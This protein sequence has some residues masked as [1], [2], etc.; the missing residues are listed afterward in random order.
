[1]TWVL[2]QSA[3]FRYTYSTI[4]L[5]ENRQLLIFCEFTLTHDRLHALIASGDASL[6]VSPEADSFT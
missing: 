6:E 5:S 4:V 2:I 1:M 3:Q